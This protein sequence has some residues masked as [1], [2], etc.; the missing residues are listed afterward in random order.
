[1]STSPAVGVLRFLRERVATEEVRALPDREV[2][3][4][5]AAGR[6]EAAFEE[7]ACRHGPL[8]FGVCRR[9]LGNLHD[10]EDAFQATFLVLSRKAGSLRRQESVASWL[11][12]VAERLSC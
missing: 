6:D 2:L 9:L 1:M 5:F 10:A 12:G 8:V 4:G 7:L 3:R 11:F